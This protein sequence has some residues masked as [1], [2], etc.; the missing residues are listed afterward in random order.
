M[1]KIRHHTN[2]LYHYYCY[3]M[4][5]PVS[6]YI[7]ILAEKSGVG[8]EVKLYLHVN[9]PVG[10][11]GQVCDFEIFS[12]QCSARVQHTLVFLMQTAEK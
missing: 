2:L 6:I 7:Y 8:I 5:K 12:F 9:E 3:Y 1:L 10:L 11:H 4:I